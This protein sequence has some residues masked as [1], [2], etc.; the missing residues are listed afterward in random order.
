MSTRQEMKQIHTHEIN[1]VEKP[2]DDLRFA[3]VLTPFNL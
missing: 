1:T 2:V 3:V